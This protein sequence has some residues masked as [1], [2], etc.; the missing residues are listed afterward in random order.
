VFVDRTATEEAAGVQAIWQELH[1]AE[2]VLLTLQVSEK[3]EKRDERCT[4]TK[5]LQIQEEAVEVQ[6]IWPKLHH[7]VLV[8]LAL[9][10]RRQTRGEVYINKQSPA[11]QPG[12]QLIT[13]QEVT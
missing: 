12:S 8:L 10:D 9:P 5:Q 11:L 6:R 1:H 4:S 7:A 13:W 2:L 3:P